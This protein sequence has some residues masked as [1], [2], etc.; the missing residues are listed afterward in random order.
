[1][2]NEQGIDVIVQP[3]SLRIFSDEEY[4]AAGTVVST[5]LSECNVVFGVRE[6]PLEQIS[7]GQS[8]CCFSH[9]IKA[10]RYNMPM[11]RHIIESNCTLLDYELV[12]NEAGRRLIVFGDFAGYACMVDALW[13]L[14]KR[15]DEQDIAN[16][17]TILKQAGEYG[18][19]EAARA[20]MSSLGR[21]IRAEGLPDRIAPL[22]CAFTGRGQVSKSAQKMLNLLPAVEIRPDDLPTLASTG[23]NSASAT[24]TNRTIPT[25]CSIRR[26]SR[27]NRAATGAGCTVTRHSFPCW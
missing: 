26:R 10:Q 9:T 6:V 21:Q 15:L 18:D 17:F 24:C 12:T 1:M 11:L 13:I 25:P 19:L 27:K 3:S 8:Y 7:P 2:K 16:P 22:V 23:S 20:A 4:K 5:D 14:G